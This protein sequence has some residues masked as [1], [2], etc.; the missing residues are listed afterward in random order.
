MSTRG[1][2]DRGMG[3]TARLVLRHA[4]RVIVLGPG[5]RVLLACH[6]DDLP[7]VAVMMFLPSQLP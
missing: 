3:D 5:D 7:P 6:N 4:G 2:S 1:V